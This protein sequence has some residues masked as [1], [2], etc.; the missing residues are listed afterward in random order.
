M[1]LSERVHRADVVRRCGIVGP[2]IG[3]RLASSGRGDEVD[4]EVRGAGESVHEHVTG[5][6]GK[7]AGPVRTEVH[8]QDQLRQSGSIGFRWG[9]AADNGMTRRGR[10]GRSLAFIHGIGEVK[11]GTGPAYRF[12]MEVKFRR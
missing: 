11:V 1:H 6:C 7:R 5:L 4:S 9:R 8:R 10:R 3:D 2:D 12:A